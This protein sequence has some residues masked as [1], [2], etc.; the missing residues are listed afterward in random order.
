MSTGYSHVNRYLAMIF[1]AAF[2]AESLFF[3]QH[4]HEFDAGEPLAAQR[5][6]EEADAFISERVLGPSDHF[7]V[8]RRAIEHY[9]VFLGYENAKSPE[10][11][12]SPH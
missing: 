12:R 6:V 4:V 1:S 9:E 2:H 7:Q 5:S 3:A 8:Y 11:V 10:E